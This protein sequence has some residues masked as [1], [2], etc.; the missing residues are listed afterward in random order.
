MRFVTFVFD[1]II[2]EVFQ[3]GDIINNK[4]VMA[5][6]DISKF[7]LFTTLP[8]P[9]SIK[10]KYEISIFRLKYRYNLVDIDIFFK[11]SMHHF[12]I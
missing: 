12:F 5:S 6:S 1:D 2:T 3:I 10:Y 7:P 4:P 9:P 11:I 8:H